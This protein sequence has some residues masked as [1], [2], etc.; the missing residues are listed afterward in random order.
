MKTVYNDEIRRTKLNT[1]FSF[2]DLERKYHDLYGY[3]M[4]IKYRD[5]V[6]VIAT[7]L[8]SLELNLAVA[9]RLMIPTGG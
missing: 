5:S 4:A 3:P 9:C 1:A 7:V 6:R 2:V 8:L